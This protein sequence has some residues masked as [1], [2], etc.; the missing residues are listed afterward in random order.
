LLAGH[1]AAVPRLAFL[2]IDMIPPYV[3]P[4]WRLRADRPVPATAHYLPQN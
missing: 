4:A 1:Q 3:R 2:A